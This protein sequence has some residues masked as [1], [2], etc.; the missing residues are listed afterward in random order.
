MATRVR[1]RART[2]SP[3]SSSRASKALRPSPLAGATVY[4]EPTFG[5]WDW[6]TDAVEMDEWTSGWKTTGDGQG[7]PADCV[8]GSDGDS[9]IVENTEYGPVVEGPIQYGDVTYGAESFGAV[10]ATPGT[11]H[12]F[13]THAG[14]TRQLS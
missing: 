12:V 11:A 7:S 8:D 10:T 9:N 3:G 6:S 14:V 2:S 5:D 1:P 13:A 4:D